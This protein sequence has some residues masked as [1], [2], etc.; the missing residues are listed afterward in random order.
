[1]TAQAATIERM[2]RN[3]AARGAT[4]SPSGPAAEDLLRRGEISPEV[5][6]DLGRIEAVLEAMFLAMG[7][8][9]SVAREE[10]DLIWDAARALGSEEISG[11]AVKALLRSLGSRLR[12]EGWD[13]RLRAVTE[14]LGSDRDLAEGA[15]ALAAVVAMADDEISAGENGLVEKLAAG[16]GIDDARFC[17][18]LD[19]LKRDA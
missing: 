14:R 11:D 13:A 6:A 7:A 17:E 3:L 18:I 12:E 9:G 16:L 2:R 1:M 8:D 4:A 15:F 10:L 5:A 19:D